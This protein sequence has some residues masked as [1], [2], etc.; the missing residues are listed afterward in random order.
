M[1]GPWQ[2][3]GSSILFSIAKSSFSLRLILYLL[4]DKLGLISL[5]GIIEPVIPIYFKFGYT[6]SDNAFELSACLFIA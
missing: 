5:R 3:Q 4:P 1:V 2:E 6:R